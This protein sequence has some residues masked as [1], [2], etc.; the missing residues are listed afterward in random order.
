MF[1]KFFWS[2]L[3]PRIHLRTI[4][5]HKH[6]GGYSLPHL[7]AMIE[8]LRIKCGSQ[9]INPLHLAPWKFYALIETGV[10]LRQYAPRLWS[11]LIPHIEKGDS[12]FHEVASN[13]AKWLKAGGSLNIQQN[14][15]SFYWQIV[16]RFY[17][18]HPVSVH[19][20]MATRLF[21]TTIKRLPFDVG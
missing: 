17:F 15:P 13:T 10:Q 9:L 21:L 7:Q 14:Q 8:A 12:F 16:N 6:D 18:R 5:G 2:S 1:V 3:G 4:I 11:N 20:S 19:P